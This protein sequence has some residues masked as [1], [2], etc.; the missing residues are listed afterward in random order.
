MGDET[1][2]AKSRD[3]KE[4]N[5]IIKFEKLPYIVFIIAVKIS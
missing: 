1:K 4:Q 5:K 3:I 2:Q